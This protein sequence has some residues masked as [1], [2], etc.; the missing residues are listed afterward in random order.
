MIVY[1]LF[2]LSYGARDLPVRLGLR[3]I[4]GATLRA[5]WVH[6]LIE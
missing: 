1:P 2:A 4:L 5:K 3:G 6:Y